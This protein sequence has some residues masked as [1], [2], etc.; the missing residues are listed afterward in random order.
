MA[1]LNTGVITRIVGRPAA[2]LVLE[3][4]ILPA[5]MR[6]RVAKPLITLLPLDFIFICCPDFL[7]VSVSMC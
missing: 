7:L 1:T 6:T 4:K 2:L 3:G 5:A